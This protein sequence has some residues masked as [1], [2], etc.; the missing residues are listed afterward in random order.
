MQGAH[1]ST[2]GVLK[3]WAP[4]RSYG[5]VI[6][7]AAACIPLFSLHSRVDGRT[8]ASPP[9]SSSRARSTC[10]LRGRDAL[11]RLA[12]GDSTGRPRMSRRSSSCARRPNSMR[13]VPA[14]EG[15]DFDLRRGEIHALVGE[16]GAGKSTLTKIMAGVVKLTSG[17]DLINGKEVS[18]DAARGAA[19]GIAMV[20]Q[21]TSLVPS[22]TVAQN[23]YLGQEQLLQSP[24]RHLHRGAAVPA[25][26]EF[27]R[28]SD[29]DRR[30]SAPPRS[31]WWR[32]P[33][34]CSTTPR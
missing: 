27:R 8:T 17:D 6:R 15:V 33:A 30:R 25:V 7:L 3:P 13:G 18:P 21:E 2:M 1:L 12:S 26:A 22:M 29:R 23:L 16:N 32:S 24:A 10:S 28:R 19:A 4:P 34:R 14:I 9:R 31:R 11:L 20:F 5:L